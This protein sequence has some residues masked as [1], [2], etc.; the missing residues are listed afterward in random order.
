MITTMRNHMKKLFFVVWII[1]ASFILSIFLVWGKGTFNPLANWAIKVDETEFSQEN[2]IKTV[3]SLINIYRNQGVNLNE[4]MIREIRKQALDV[5][6]NNA[7]TISTALKAGF[8]V[9]PTELSE[10]LASIKEFQTNGR[11]DK[12]K[13]IEVLKLN[14]MTP[15]QF[16]KELYNE[17]L[18]KKLELSVYE[19][20]N[21]SDYELASIARWNLMKA[22]VECAL[23]DTQRIKNEIRVSEDEIKDEY[24]KNKGKYKKNST[25]YGVIVKAEFKN[26][27]DKKKIVENLKYIKENSKTPADLEK[28]ALSKGISVK[29]GNILDD[30]DLLKLKEKIDQLNEGEVSSILKSDNKY[31]LVGITKKTPERILSLEEAR[32]IVEDQLKNAKI[33]NYA[34]NIITRLSKNEFTGIKE[35]A[36]K[37]NGSYKELNMISRGALKIDGVEYKTLGIKALTKNKGEVG[38]VIE[39]DKLIVFRVIEKIY[40]NS[41]EIEAFKRNHRKQILVSKS[42]KVWVTFINRAKEKSKIE[43]NKKVKE[44]LL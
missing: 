11:F 32:S 3:E 28:M 31:I 10:I 13:Y 44:M 26:D 43:V 16:E 37:L 8:E 23:I 17:L 15:A 33:N 38:Y 9:S 30:Q 5:L 35:L 1:V 4:S 24:E 21:L 6:I 22:T 25:I 29:K 20:V 18:S 40:P 42:T 14:R 12:N 41:E 7:L 34:E 27:E 2:Y 36:N 39:N 19:G